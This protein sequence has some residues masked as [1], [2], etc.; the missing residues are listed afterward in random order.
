M[1]RTLAS[2][3][4]LAA[5]ALPLAATAQVRPSS[6]RPTVTGANAFGE[7]PR[8]SAFLCVPVPRSTDHR[9][10][11]PGCAASCRASALSF[12]SVAAALHGGSGALAPV[13][14][15]TAHPA[16]QRSLRSTT[17]HASAPREAAVT[18]RY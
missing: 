17:R 18:C 3:A 11:R 13:I 10:T 9:P 6:D 1:K 5:L 2:A 15:Q 7:K 16:A 14:N 8:V 4:L 12:A